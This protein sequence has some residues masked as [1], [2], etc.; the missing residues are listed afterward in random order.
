ML[1][2]DRSTI[3]KTISHIIIPAPEIAVALGM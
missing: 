1:D 2:M 3:G